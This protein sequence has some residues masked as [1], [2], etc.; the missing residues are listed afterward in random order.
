M[1]VGVALMYGAGV[2]VCCAFRILGDILS[3][4][5]FFLSSLLCSFLVSAVVGDRSEMGWKFTGVLRACG[6]TCT[7]IYG[8]VRLIMK[9]MD[10]W[11]CVLRAS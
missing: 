8:C 11:S 2:F 5:F 9:W 4:F 3:S 10:V 7:S 1:P 6:N